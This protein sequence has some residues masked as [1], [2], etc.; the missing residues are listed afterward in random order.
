MKVLHVIST[1][2]AVNGGTTAA[3]SGLA[4]S[5]LEAGLEVA[6]LTTFSDR[7]AEEVVGPL[8]S[9]GVNVIEHGPSPGGVFNAGSLQATVRSAVGLAGL[10]HVHGLWE[11]VIHCA[12]AQAL[13]Q[14]RPLVVSPHGMLDPWSL[15]QKSWKK[16]IYRALRLDRHLH[17]ADM[18]HCA[19]RREQEN[20]RTL[21]PTATTR[22]VPHGLNLKEFRQ[23]PVAGGFR[24][25]FPE[26]GT[27]PLVLFLSRLH[28]VKGLEVL[29]PAFRSVS[30]RLPGWRLVIAGPPVTPDYL[31]K[32]QNLA[33][34]EGLLDGGRVVF[35]GMLDQVQRVQAMA[36]A[37]VFVLPSYQENFGVV[38]AEAAAAGLP[39]VVSEHVSLSDFVRS[40][41]IGEVVPLEKAKLA[42]SIVSVANNP[43][44]GTVGPRAR[45][46]AFAAFDRGP[47]GERWR[48][49]YEEL[50]SAAG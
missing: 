16:K 14:R 17:N 28:P 47:I 24:Q 20:L 31:K 34:R 12:C 22:V 42:D 35:V 46:A 49:I 39:L 33:S 2:D 10:V 36:D 45:E 18:I 5:Q 32:L 37:S 48:R 4:V 9:R 6:V 30:G 13:Q 40:E 27:G 44:R 38:V 1:L 25:A 43:Q 15:R 19:T 11:W 21:L 7:S 23:M 8:R 50:L 29:I 26:T 3:L 41:C